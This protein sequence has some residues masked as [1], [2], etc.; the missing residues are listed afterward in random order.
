MKGYQLAV[1]IGGTFTDIV[2]LSPDGTVSTKKIPSTPEDYSRAIEDGTRAL[3]GELGVSASEIREF[4][5]GT[6]VASNAII[7]RRGARVALVTTRGFR[8]VLEIGRFRH[9]QAL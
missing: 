9:A 7:E 6:T 5:H 8:D 4:V 3:L 2:L 1:D